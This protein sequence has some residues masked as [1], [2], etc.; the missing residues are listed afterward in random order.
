[1]KINRRTLIASIATTIAATTL[2]FA[3]SNAIAAQPVVEIIGYAHP[4]VQTALKPLR[5]W[6][7]TQGTKLRVVEIDMD[8]SA[9]EKRMQAIGLKGHIPI[10]ILIDGKYKHAR[11]DGSAVEFVSFPANT[12]GKGWTTDDVQ[13]VLKDRK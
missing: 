6:L 13:S 8:S 10:V 4:P 12:P 9:A 7:A 5:E 11:Q 1:M 2:A 3:A